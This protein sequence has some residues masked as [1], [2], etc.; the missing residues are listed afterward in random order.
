MLGGDAVLVILL[1]TLNIFPTSFYCFFCSLW[2]ILAELLLVPNNKTL[3]VKFHGYTTVLRQTI[4]TLIRDKHL[5]KLVRVLATAKA[6]WNFLAKL[7]CKAHLNNNSLKTSPKAVVRRRSIKK[8]LLKISLNAHAS[9]CARVSC[10]IELQAQVCNFIKKETLAQVF[11]WNFGEILR[12]TVFNRTPVAASASL[13]S[14]PSKLYFD[15]HQELREG[16]CITL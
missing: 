15:T 10:L 9:T 8:V 3:M 11:S 12:S 5:V 7:V 13:S 1:L 2:I 16:E 4:S 14:N 6:T